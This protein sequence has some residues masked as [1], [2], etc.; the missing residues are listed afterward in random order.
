[1]RPSSKSMQSRPDMEPVVPSSNC[2]TQRAEGSSDSLKALR[3]QE[4]SEILPLSPDSLLSHHFTFSKQTSLPSPFNHDNS[5]ADSRN[6][7]TRQHNMS[8]NITVT[9]PLDAVAAMQQTTDPAKMADAL[10]T[11]T[12]AFVAGVKA[13]PHRVES[14][15]AIK[16]EDDDEDKLS[17]RSFDSDA[18][19][20]APPPSKKAKREPASQLSP[21]H[22]S[23]VVKTLTCKRINVRFR[24]NASC[25]YLK[26][27]IQHQDGTPVDQQ[28]LIFEGETAAGR[29]HV[30]GCK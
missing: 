9:V 14:T 27:L 24:P 28:R 25:Y 29:R 19:A 26:M 2:P 4:L 7:L 5:R 1:M 20:S 6:M 17:I 30:A 18:P 15:A 16:D 23:V 3:R 12:K 11:I 8:V 21:P 13:L 10:S 22:I